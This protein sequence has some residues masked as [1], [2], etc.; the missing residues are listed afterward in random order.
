M[1]EMS[2]KDY[3]LKHGSFA[4]RVSVGDWKEAVK[5]AADLLVKSG[6]A[7]PRYG[8][9]IIANTEKLGPYYILGPGLAMPHARPEGGVLQNGFSLVTLETPVPFG[10]EENDPIDVLI[11]FA[12][13]SAEVQ[14]KQSIV[15]VVELIDSPERVEALRKAR[16][17]EDLA[18]LFDRIKSD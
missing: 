6:S 14:N 4:F 5:T 10:D 7:E 16:T 15:E 1:D 17:A 13:V 9:E 11:T 12:A 8:E 18:S 2:L 3:L